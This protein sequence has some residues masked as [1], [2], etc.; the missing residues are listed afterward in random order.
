MSMDYGGPIKL[1]ITRGKQ[2]TTLQTTRQRFNVS[3]KTI[4]TLKLPYNN[5]EKGSC[6]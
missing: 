6:G 1:C 5:E 2:E 4:V 3:S